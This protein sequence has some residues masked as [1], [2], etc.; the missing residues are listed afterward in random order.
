MVLLA[1]GSHFH[2]RMWSPARLVP[3]ATY[4]NQVVLDAIIAVPEDWRRQFCTIHCI[5]KI[6]SLCCL[7][8]GL[9]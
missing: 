5:P 8:S 2:F 7:K 1:N 3:S 6:E 4:S 9:G